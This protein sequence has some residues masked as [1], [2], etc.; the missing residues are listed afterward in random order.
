LRGR[1]QAINMARVV[2]DALQTGATREQIDKLLM[3]QPLDGK[4]ETLQQNPRVIFNIIES[5][6]DM[7]NF[8]TCVGDY[9]G[10]AMQA[11]MASHENL[12]PAPFKR[13]II[14]DV[15]YPELT[16][17]KQNVTIIFMRADLCNQY[18]AQYKGVVKTHVLPFDAALASI[19]D[20]PDHKTFIIGGRD[21]YETSKKHV[22][23]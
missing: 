21:L 8:V 22:R 1:H 3:N 9:F 7:K 6:E 20:Y 2:E 12:H 16:K 23:R 13:L 11:R 5:P 14:A 4:F 17:I 10:R 15:F 18:R 19:K